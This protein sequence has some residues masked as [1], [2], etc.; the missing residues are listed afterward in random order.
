MISLA[1]EQIIKCTL[2]GNIMNLTRFCTFWYMYLRICELKF[3]FICSRYTLSKKIHMY[4]KYIDKYR[5]LA[6]L[7]SHLSL[8]YLARIY[9]IHHSSYMNLAYLVLPLSQFMW[10]FSYSRVKQFKFDWIL[11]VKSS[12]FLKMKFIYIC[13]LRQKYYKLQ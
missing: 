4:L 12:I 5:A 13:K 6:S 3:T 1:Y 8:S 7:P 11:R 9:E 2:C 10:H